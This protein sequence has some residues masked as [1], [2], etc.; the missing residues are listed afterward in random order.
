MFEDYRGLLTK[1]EFEVMELLIEG[2]YTP[3]EVSVHL[4]KT[5]ASVYQMKH[6]AIKRLRDNRDLV[7]I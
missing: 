3:K 4:G 5:I 1:S 7:G 2:G 6:R